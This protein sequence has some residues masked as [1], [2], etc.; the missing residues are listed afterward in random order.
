ML[1]FHHSD[2]QVWCSI[3]IIDKKVSTSYLNTVKKHSFHV[4]ALCFSIIFFVHKP[5]AQQNS[6]ESKYIFLSKGITPQ[7][8]LILTFH[9]WATAYTY[10]SKLIN[11]HIEVFDIRCNCNHHLSKVQLALDL[12]SFIPD[13]RKPAIAVSTWSW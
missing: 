6:H 8:S 5:N 13:T 3:A 1:H 2:S 12:C 9:T 7:I 4:S 10:C 11:R